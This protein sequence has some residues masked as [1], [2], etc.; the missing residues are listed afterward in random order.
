MRKVPLGICING[1]DI[2]FVDNIIAIYGNEVEYH[3]FGDTSYY[4]ECVKIFEQYRI[5]PF[6]HIDIERTSMKDIMYY[7][8]LNCIIIVKCS[9]NISMNFYKLQKI[10]RLILDFY[11]NTM[12]DVYKMIHIIQTDYQLYNHYMFDID[13]KNVL[14]YNVQINDKNIICDIIIGY[15][16]DLYKIST[17]HGGLIPYDKLYYSLKDRTLLYENSVVNNLQDAYSMMK[18]DKCDTCPV[19]VICP[20]YGMTDCDTLKLSYT[21]IID[22]IIKYSKGV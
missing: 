19:S 10:H 18:C 4:G 17:T 13:L 20:K 11:D 15:Y 1:D 12:D 9:K 3:I 21:R 2:S 8:T 16:M 22:D 7:D 14:E 5:V 6:I